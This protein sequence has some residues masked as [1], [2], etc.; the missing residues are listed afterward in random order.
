VGTNPTFEVD[1]KVRIETL[2]LGYAG[3]LY[4]STIAV[5]FLEKIRNQQTFADGG[6]LVERIHMDEE[7]ARGYF[8]SRRDLL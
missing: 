3:T 1:R 6:T 8:E 4:G 2:L 7:I 5:D